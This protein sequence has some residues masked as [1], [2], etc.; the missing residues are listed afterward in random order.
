MDLDIDFLD[1]GF[2][3]EMAR[4]LMRTLAI[5]FGAGVEVLGGTRRRFDIGVLFGH[6]DEFLDVVTPRVAEDVSVYDGSA[7]Q[8]L[9]LVVSEIFLEGLENFC[10]HGTVAGSHALLV[11]DFQ[12]RVVL[13]DLADNFDVPVGTCEMDWGIKLV[14][15]EIDLSTFI[16]E[17]PGDF[18]VASD[19]GNMKRGPLVVCLGVQVD[20]FVEKKFDSFHKSFT[21]YD[22][23]TVPVIESFLIDI[24]WKFLVLIIK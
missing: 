20:I 8:V 24:K 19:T 21:D 3:G 6:L 18:C 5:F 11:F 22:M 9:L 12:V 1:P 16:E 4:P 13:Q 10:V 14:V 7:V 2:V 15:L 17:H 23:E